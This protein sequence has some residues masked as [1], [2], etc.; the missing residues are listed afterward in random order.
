MARTTEIMRFFSSNS[1]VTKGYRDIH[2]FTEVT[3][4]TPP[5]T[6]LLHARSLLETVNRV[7]TG[8]GLCMILPVPGSKQMMTI[9]TLTPVSSAFSLISYRRTG[10]K[11]IGL[12]PL[13]L[14]PE[15]L[16][17]SLPHKNTQ[18]TMSSADQ[19]GQSKSPS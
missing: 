15:T 17:L 13:S 14:L 10:N 18:D 4:A 7:E 11:K 3:Y 1:S 12:L 9:I 8:F 2:F 6:V 5:L 19:S 16:R